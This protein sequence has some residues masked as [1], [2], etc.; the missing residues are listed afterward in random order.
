M[1]KAMTFTDIP[2][3]PFSPYLFLNLLW[4][5]LRTCVITIALGKKK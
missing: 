3:K 1:P 4:V 5:D 2:V